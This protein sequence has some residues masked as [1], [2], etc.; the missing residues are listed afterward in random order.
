MRTN[1]KKYTFGFT[2]VELMIVVAIIGLLAAVA[3]PAYQK[4][5]LKSKSAGAPL[6]IKSIY[7]SALVFGGKGQMTHRD[8]TYGDVQ[9]K[10]SPRFSA[11]CLYKEGATPSSDNTIGQTKKQLVQ[12]FND[13]V[14]YSDSTRVCQIHRSYSTPSF[15]L[16]QERPTS[17]GTAFIPLSMYSY[18]V[19]RAKRDVAMVAEYGAAFDNTL[20]IAAIGDLDGDNIPGAAGY[21][22][23]NCHISDSQAANSP[24]NN[25]FNLDKLSI[26]ARGMYIDNEGEIQGTQMI[27]INELE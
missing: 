25:Y 9:C 4:Y 18:F 7:D 27:T 19:L 23:A 5:I 1:I 26:Y 16:G 6:L 15:N 13:D 24:S 8:A 22:P 14:T 20:M 10:P 11:V 21:Q 12:Y 17:G 3:V 2:L